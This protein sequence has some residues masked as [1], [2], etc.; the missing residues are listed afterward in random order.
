LA[1]EPRAGVFG[2]GAAVEVVTSLRGTDVVVVVVGV[3]G[4]V[5]A[6]CGGANSTGGLDGAVV[7]VAV[8]VVGVVVGVVGAVVVVVVVVVTGDSDGVD[9][10]TTLGA[11]ISSDDGGGSTGAAAPGGS[12]AAGSRSTTLTDKRFHWSTS[13]CLRSVSLMVCTVLLTAASL[14]CACCHWPCWINCATWAISV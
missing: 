8:G 11:G 7:G 6:G 5:L 14:S 3:G 13:C 1:V 10:S 2:S 4:V 9:P 12:V